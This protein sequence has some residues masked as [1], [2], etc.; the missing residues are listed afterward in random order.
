MC[1]L[2]GAQL[3]PRAVL[4]AQLEAER[5]KAVLLASAMCLCGGD[6]SWPQQLTLGSGRGRVA[7]LHVHL[8]LGLWAL[9]LEG[10]AQPAAHGPILIC[11][12]VSPLP[13]VPPHWA[14]WQTCSLPGPALAA[15]VAQLRWSVDVQEHNDAPKSSWGALWPAQPHALLLALA[16][17]ADSVHPGERGQVSPTSPC[18]SSQRF[19][20]F[21]LMQGGETTRASKGRAHGALR[22][23]A[24]GRLFL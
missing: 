11:T 17:L 23:W 18:S 10:R 4:W 5:A 15:A 9:P 24:G 8:W 12:T 6:G 16:L 7:S 19:I 3:G 2:H 20:N 22:C 13:S 1:V 14:A 21:C